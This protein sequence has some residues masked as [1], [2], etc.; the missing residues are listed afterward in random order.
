MGLES[1]KDT[2]STISSV[3]ISITAIITLI[4]MV[5][6]PFRKWIGGT[7]NRSIGKRDEN[8]I[9]EL[10]RVERSFMS[11]CDD[12]EKKIDAVSEENKSNERDRLRSE[13]FRFGNYARKHEV[14]AADEF[15]SLQRDFA[16]Y[17]RLGGNDIAHDEYEFITDY[18]NNQ[19]WRVKH[20]EQT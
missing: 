9:T 15:R 5:V 14:I 12:L 20:E 16:K 7:I 3:A 4:A 1:L 8:M 13:I 19:R 6:K 10:K 11:R 17:T 18:Y 2:L